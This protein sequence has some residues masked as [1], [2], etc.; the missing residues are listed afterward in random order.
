[1]LNSS[2]AGR[3]SGLGADEA[4]PAAVVEFDLDQQLAFAIHLH[5]HASVSA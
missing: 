1:L 4:L 5:L 2:H 3:T